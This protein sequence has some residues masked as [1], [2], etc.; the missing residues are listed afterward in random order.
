VSG[1]QGFGGLLCL[2]PAIDCQQLLPLKGGDTHVAPEISGASA[3]AMVGG[4][5][6]LLLLGLERLSREKVN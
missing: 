1:L 5:V 6:L 4:L 3:S 2:W